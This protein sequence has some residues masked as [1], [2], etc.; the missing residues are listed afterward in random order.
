MIINNFD[1][2]QVCKRKEIDDSRL[3]SPTLSF[4]SARSSFSPMNISKELDDDEIR[5]TSSGMC[6][7]F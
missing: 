1:S 6:F 7:E 3:S 4:K 5:I 2:I